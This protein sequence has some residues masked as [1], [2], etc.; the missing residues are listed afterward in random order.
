MLHRQCD[1]RFFL[2]Y[3]LTRKY[4][5]IGTTKQGMQMMGLT[6]QGTLTCVLGVTI[7]TLLWASTALAQNN[8]ALFVSPVRLIFDPSTNTSTMTVSNKTDETKYYEVTMLDQV[9][10]A[11][12]GIQQLDTFDYSSKRMLRFM[13]RKII[14]AGGERQVVRVMAQRPADLPDGDYHTHIF[15]NEV[16]APIS[17]TL[18]ISGTEI[19][20]SKGPQFKVTTNGGVGIPVIVQNG[21][22]SA[23]LSLISASVIPLPAGAEPGTPHSLSVNL[24]R[25]GNAE[26]LAFLTVTTGDVASPTVLARPRQMLVYRE[27]DEVTVPVVLDPEAASY[28]G[29]VRL[30]LNTK[31]NG[32]DLVP[33]GEVVTVTLP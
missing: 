12:G 22:I 2:C 16:P 11:S 33:Y 31:V 9:M 30:H 6:R 3:A 27:R 26:A 5:N 1:W 15:F 20:P 28:R 13:P 14:L 8:T 10:T 17:T 19:S 23:S 25:L 4:H 18:P 32:R 24:Q 29:P 21:A 7:S